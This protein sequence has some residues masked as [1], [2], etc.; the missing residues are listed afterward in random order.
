LLAIHDIS[1][2]TRIHKEGIKE[3]GIPDALEGATRQ[4]AI[5]LYSGYFSPK[6]GL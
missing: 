1:K 2:Y 4:R 6:A 5:S 3:A